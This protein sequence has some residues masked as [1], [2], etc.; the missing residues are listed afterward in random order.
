MSPKA[1]VVPPSGLSEP[2]EPSQVKPEDKPKRQLA[3]EQEENPQVIAQKPGKQ[4]RER[5]DKG[6]NGQK[7]GSRGGEAVGK[8]EDGREVVGGREDQGRVKGRL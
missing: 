6:T 4:Y 2:S 1:Q 3:G 8:E 5:G 7:E